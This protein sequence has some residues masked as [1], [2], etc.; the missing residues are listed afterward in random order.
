MSSESHQ[1][2]G[3]GE[4][5]AASKSPEIVEK[6]RDDEGNSP[7]S[8]S[9]GG[10]RE[11]VV[12]GKSVASMTKRERKRDREK[13]RRSD[14]N[15][16]F[17]SLMELIFRINPRRRE[18]AEANRKGGGQYCKGKSEESPLLSR[19]DIVNEAVET[20]G[21]IHLENEERKGVI[22]HLSRGLL[23]SRTDVPPPLDPVAGLA[24]M[25]SSLAAARELEVRSEIFRKSVLFCG[26]LLTVYN[27]YHSI[28]GKNFNVVSSFKLC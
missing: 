19:L 12:E 13:Q 6:K 22:L 3:N 1:S 5:P 7:P 8:S 10:R 14:L 9:W 2:N 24:P 23:A 20:M 11:P 25:Q 26:I 18:E 15:Y 21:R 16:A 4:D 28:R 17:D 27:F